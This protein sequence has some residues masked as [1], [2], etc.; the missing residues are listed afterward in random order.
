MARPMGLK[1]MQGDRATPSWGIQPSRQENAKLL[2]CCGNENTAFY[3]FEIIFLIIYINY[4]KI[5]LERGLHY[6]KHMIS[7]N[8]YRPSHHFISL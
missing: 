3:I 7:W 4:N 5:Q 8:I 1:V 2:K 6:R